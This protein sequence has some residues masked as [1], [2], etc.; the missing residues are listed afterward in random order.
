[1][2][3]KIFKSTVLVSAS[4]LILGIVFVMGILYQYFGKQLNSELEKEAQ[5]LSYGIEAQGE[6][7]LEQIK[8]TDS[9][10]T[11]MDKTG[12][13]IFDNEADPAEMENHENREEVQEAL[14]KGR[15]SAV[16]I[17]DTLSE[18]T[19]YYAL[20]LSD[21]SVI[22]VSSTQY[23]VFAL[24]LQ[25]VQPTLCII[26]VMLILAGIFASRI[27]G[28]IVEP[29]NELNLEKPEEN[30]VYEEVAPL[31]SKINRQNRQIRTQLEEA[32]RSQEE[33]S[34]IT[35]NMQE[36]LLVID[37]YTMILSGNTS[38]WKIFQVNESLVGQSVYSL[39]RDEEFRKVIEQVLEGKHASTLLRLDQEFVQ[40]IANPV[41]REGKTVGAVL[42]LMNETEKIQRENLRREFSANVSHELKTPLTSISGFAEIIQ[43]GF[44]KE[45]DI[46]KFAGR[47]YREAQRL[48]QLVDDTIKISQL[49]E[50]EN[51]YEWENTDLY[52]V[53]KNV[54]SNLKEIAEKKDVHLYID[55]ERMICRTVRPILEEV[56]YNLCD[57]GI[58]Y[59]KQNGTVTISLIDLGSDAQIAVEDNGIGI[60]REDRNRVFERFYRVDKSHSK[61][62]GGTGLGLS[63]VKHGVG[64]LGGTLGMI[65]EENKG[66]RITI[67]IP[68]NRKEI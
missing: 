52:S 50:G 68:K 10:I 56:L 55:G 29:I 4:V 33:F 39:D 60:P 49:D 36:G 65:S 15:G 17:S 30:E 34:I 19:V 53:A 5:Y 24:I 25:L 2:T 62:I 7:F 59:N 40:L 23:S 26:F 31:L 9:R 47:I 42:L 58:K 35:E 3:K 21:S 43:D 20:R 38:A 51:P 37:P 8:N 54:C 32:R 14:S 48:I 6:E 41:E 13:V 61:E 12:T 1:M 64:F 63:I 46:K 16:R 28:K 11:Y 66:T 44:V 67:T 18:K 45:E 27:A 57:N 22:R